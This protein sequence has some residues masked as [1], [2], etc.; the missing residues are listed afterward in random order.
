MTKIIN[1]LAGSGCG[2]T[3]T[4]AGLF[5]EMKKMGLSCELVQE[6]VKNWAYE[7][8]DIVQSDQALILEKQ[9]A[10]EAIL[11]GKVDYIITDSPFILSPIYEKFN[12][13]EN[14]TLA[15]A[16]KL[17]REANQ[18]G[19]EHIN[20]LLNRTK[21]FDPHGRYED[22]ETAIKIDVA[23]KEFLCYHELE[24]YELTKN[25]QDAKVYEI[26]FNIEENL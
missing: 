21:G 6:F 10:R 13:D 14:G 24:F 11:Y 4:A 3:T 9:Y 8:R 2:K 25:E 5:Y 19:M 7:G 16:L 18:S 22:E 26:L 1:I 17:L 15:P 12:Y 23:V 20:F